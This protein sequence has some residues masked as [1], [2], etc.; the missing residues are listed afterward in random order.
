M[1][2]P[3][4]ISINQDGLSEL[5]LC[6]A[7]FLKSCNYTKRPSLLFYFC[8]KKKVKKEHTTPTKHEK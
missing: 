3:I 6:E 5:A 4:P 1:R 7:S 8:K 2:I